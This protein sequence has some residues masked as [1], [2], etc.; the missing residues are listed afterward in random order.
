[1]KIKIF[2]ITLVVSLSAIV[3]TANDPPHNENSGVTCDGCH[4][5]VL[6][7]TNP[8]D[9]PAG[10]EER[11]ALYDAVCTGTCHTD[12]T[13]AY[14]AT[15]APFVKGHEDARC[16][17]CH[18]GHY[19]YGQSLYGMSYPSYYI[20]F[21][22]DALSATPDNDPDRPRT[23]ITYDPDSL[24]VK[25]GSQWDTTGEPDNDI[26]V[27]LG[28]LAAKTSDGR[29]ALFLPSSASPF[30]TMMVE[31]I[32]T[33]VNTITVK[34]TLS[35]TPSEFGLAYG[36]LINRDIPYA[37][38]SGEPVMFFDNTGEYSFANND[39]LASGHD[40]TPNGICQVCH[41]EAVGVDH[42]RN[43]GTQADHFS[44]YNCTKNCHKHTKGFLHCKE[45]SPICTDCHYAG[46]PD[47]P[48]TYCSE[49]L[50][51]CAD[52]HHTGSHAIHLN[53]VAPRGPGIFC[54]SCHDIDDIPYFKSGTDVNDD[55]KYSLSETDVCDTCHS[56][57]GTYP[58]PD[59]AYGDDPLYAPDLGAKANWTDRVYAGDYT[60]D[61]EGHNIYS[62][63]YTLKE[64]KE[65]WCATCHDEEPARID[66]V[67]APNVIGDEDNS[68]GEGIYGG[69]GFYK[70]G[71]GLPAGEAYDYKG[72]LLEPE[73]VNGA[74]RPVACDDCHDFSTSHIDGNARTFD[75]SDGCD[76]G[77]YQT[78]YRLDLVGGQDPMLVPWPAATPNSADNYRLCASCHDT[79]PFLTD[80]MDKTNL[81]TT[82]SDGTQNRHY[83]HLELSNQLKYAADYSGAENSRITCVICHNVHGS[84]RLAMIR[85]GK[86][87]SEEDEHKPGLMI[88]YNNEDIVT[89]NTTNSDPP[90]PENVP[91]S[92]SVG[93]IWRGETASNLCE[94]C[95][96]NDNTTKE[97]RTPFQDVSVAPTL[98]WTGEAGYVADGVSP[99][100]GASGATFTFRVKYTDI[101][102]DAPSSINLLIDTDNDG[103]VDDTYAMSGTDAGD[104]I[105]SN[106]RIYTKDLVLTDSV[107]YKFAASYGTDPATGSPTVWRAV[108]LLAGEV[109]HAP[110]LA[111]VSDTCR[112]QGVSPATAASGTDFEFYVQ[113][114]DDDNQCP[115]ISDVPA[116]QVW[117]DEND[118]GSYE[119]SE[120]HNLAEDDDQ[121]SDCTSTGSAKLYGL[122]VAL[123]HPG[124]ESDGLLNY[125]FVASDG[126]EAATGDPT[127]TQSVTII[128]SG[129]TPVTVCDSECDATSIQA[130][131]TAAL[132][133]DHVTLVHEGTYP[134]NLVLDNSGTD[135]SNSKVYAVCGPDET[136]ISNAGNVVKLQNVTGIVIDGFSIT[137]GSTGIYSNGGSATI[138]N[139]KIHDNNNSTGQGGGLYVGSGILTV[140]NSEIYSNTSLR[141]SAA[142][143]NAENGHSFTNTKI[144]DNEA[145]YDPGTS[146]SGSAGAVYT[147]SSGVTFT[148]VTI[149]NNTSHGNG[150]AV[151]AF[152]SNVTFYRSTIT[153]NIST[154][155]SGGVIA[156]GNG[157]EYAYLE[158]CIVA[159][160]QAPA[161]GVFF[162]NGS[163]VTAVNSTFA[164]NKAT[165]G[166][167]GV[168]WQQDGTCEFRNSILWNNTASGEGHIA[169][170]DFPGG[171]MTITDTVIAS[172]S[173]GI[174]TNA[175]YFAGNVTPSVSGYVSESD[176][177]F[178]DAEN[179]DY[180]MKN[181]S[182]AVDQGTGSGAP[183][184]DIDGDARPFD[185]TGLGDGVDDYDIGA[186]EVTDPAPIDSLSTTNPTAIES[187][188]VD[189]DASIVMS[190]FQVNCDDTGDSQCILSSV[191]VNDIGTGSS[192]DWDNLEIYIDK[193]TDF[194]GATFIGQEA[195]WDGS[196][197]TV[198]LDQGT[199]ADRTVTN[200][201]PKYVFIVYDITEA[202]EGAILQ[203]SVTQVNVKFPDIGV[204]G[205]SYKSNVVAVNTDSLSTSNNTAIQATDPGAGQANIVMQR[206]EAECSA[207]GNN[208]CILS[209]ITVNDLGTA[210]TG[211]WDSLK[212]FIDTDTDFSG[213]TLIGQTFFDGTSTAVPL[214][215][216]TAADRTVTNGTSKYIFIVYDINSEA[217]GKTIRSMVTAVGVESPDNGSTGFVYN[218]NLLTIQTPSGGDNL[219]TS[220]PAAVHAEY[221]DQGEDAAVMERFQVDCD[222]TDD[223]NCILS[224]IAVDDLGTASTGDWDNLKIYID[225]DT[226]FT[227]AVLIGQTS[228]WD[229]TSTVVSLSLGTEGDRTVTNGTPKYVFIVYDLNGSIAVDTTLQS[230]VTAV[231]VSYPDN[232]VTGITYDSDVVTVM[233][234]IYVGSGEFYETIQAAVDA[235]SDGDI[236]I[237]DDGTYEEHIDITKVVHIYSANGP[238]DTI[239]DGTDTDRPVSFSNSGAGT[240][241]ISGFTITNG[242]VFG[243]GGAGIYVNTAQPTIDNCIIT[244]N[245]AGTLDGGG[246]KVD[247][248][249][250]DVTITNSII[251]N[252]TGGNGGGLYLPSG[253]NATIS[254]VVFDQ[255]TGD[256]GGAI[257]F[258]ATDSTTSITDS[259]FTG[260]SSSQGGAFF[261]QG[262]NGIK[263]SRCTIT[264]NHASALQYS[265]GVL[266]T[267]NACY[268][269]FENCIIA[270]NYAPQGGVVS[271]NGGTTTF[272]NCT[273]ANNTATGEYS[274]D[275]G[276][277]AYICNGLVN[278]TN[279][280][281]WGNSATSGYGHNVYRTCTGPSG[282]NVGSVNYSDF[283]TSGLNPDPPPTWLNPSYMYQASVTGGNNIVEDPNFDAGGTY[284]LT[285]SSTNVID[286]GTSSGAPSVDIDGDARDDGQPD[287]G[288]DEF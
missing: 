206:F 134:E 31:F 23:V 263:F 178:V 76:S 185:C 119:A 39:G 158:N 246:I 118:D 233:D 91:L 57:G 103:N 38:S 268:I 211:D 121:D 187:G 200:G 43:D 136:T 285:S 193:D 20:L 149:E 179:G 105:Y 269:I 63:D 176:P 40:S 173:D 258:N 156:L 129:L 241:T 203:S 222:N 113:Y 70:S 240:S 171:S 13:G 41:T 175:P 9:L 190:R 5:E 220:N 90:D 273:I 191:T 47:A 170:F 93:T 219:S 78:G 16:V 247:N 168:L 10:S 59:G 45:S 225:T 28:M 107:Q 210:T 89:V 137:G 181:F 224:S 69:W 133:V 265:G 239:I 214:D 205:L 199:Q 127:G 14:H 61:E 197:E 231:G 66:G 80:S 275:G 97:D 26:E 278:M 272:T 106:G 204:T 196:T 150:G 84:T 49:A 216:G 81:I 6:F 229:G 77:D 217:G 271:P 7:Q 123:S 67:Y 88:W 104:A 122:S 71:H 257:Y 82:W 30:G 22:G 245:D 249:A 250:S 19:Q 160:N 169:W 288:A 85:D 198:L 68:E 138:N 142:V 280:I 159:D 154:A 194:A 261:M 115:G 44:G 100:A 227:G 221:A 2:I 186:D 135:Y 37:T 152:G 34:G 184:V 139:C 33:E 11:K 24:T 116:M 4:G 18:F 286:A 32:D 267:G 87:I 60:R 101:S 202:A 262:V 251:S 242:S 157:M 277:I 62:G 218:A 238:D 151:N 223:G 274:S 117:I 177:F 17:D 252:N 183:S 112:Y 124:G 140:V 226:S 73:L 50:T 102:N 254:N 208:T 148:D 21:S 165:A 279:C 110:E 213:A 143:F 207:T 99:D 36:Q 162:V 86:L 130:G 264:G 75:C 72:G 95:H 58:D 42:W 108:S 182:P 3:A 209:D 230:R 53:A 54:D 145:I 259:T 155:G 228:S 167:G 244:N 243:T 201:T 96:Y 29:G 8:L 284:H 253:T 174:P 92:A 79:D 189:A 164:G 35:Y 111:W 126:T 276:G 163:A 55:D 98:D 132:G 56:P 147:N 161:G 114:T 283:D 266:T 144:H 248:A 260:N 256:L 234:A 192:G 109:N 166:D 74:E 51:N 12:T 15:T 64:N 141:G 131:V 172:G 153:G 46:S 188:P 146:W 25:S 83:Y 215:Q 27:G 235:A 282:A 65:K 195:S 120:K 125:R 212:I 281:A 180:H 287:M 128:D 255:N 232:G 270:D 1:L 94:H 48:E 237:V 236:I 52:C